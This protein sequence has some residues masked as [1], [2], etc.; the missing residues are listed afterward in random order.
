MS[1][2]LAIRNPLGKRPRNIEPGGDLCQGRTDAIEHANLE[3]I[4]LTGLRND[5]TGAAIPSHD[6]YHTKK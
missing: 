2:L 5:M 3:T 1:W 4:R 6:P